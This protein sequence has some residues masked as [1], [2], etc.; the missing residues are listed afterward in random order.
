MG[1]SLDVSEAG[2]ATVDALLGDHD[3][4]YVKWDMNRDHVQGSGSTGSAGTHAQTL[5]LYALLDELRRAAIN[6]D[7]P[8]TS[9][10]AHRALETVSGLVD[11]KVQTEAT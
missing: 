3:I 7:I 5:A 11:G 9:A 10:D 1:G 6:I 4:A 2:G 8:V